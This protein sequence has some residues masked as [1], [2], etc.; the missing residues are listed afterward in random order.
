MMIFA[1]GAILMGMLTGWNF[2][3]GDLGRAAAAL[4][5]TITM[6]I[7]LIREVIA[8]AVLSYP[9]NYKGDN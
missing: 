2:N 1:Y 3:H 9:Y 4:L 5:L 7:N 6:L 8:P